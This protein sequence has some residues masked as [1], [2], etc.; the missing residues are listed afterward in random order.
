MILNS[1]IHILT[2]T[3][4]K[5]IEEKISVLMDVLGFHHIKANENK[6]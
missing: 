1:V 3:G 5:I 2:K 6:N 4:P